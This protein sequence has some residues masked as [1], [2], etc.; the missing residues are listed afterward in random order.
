MELQEIKDL[1]IQYDQ[2]LEKQVQLNMH[3]LRKVELE[4]TRSALRKTATDPIFSLIFGAL[5]FIA[6]MPFTMNHI[7]LLPYAV[8]ALALGLYAVLLVIDSAYRLSII[9]KI[10]YEGPI[11]EI[12]SH[13]EKLRIHNLRYTLSLNLSWAILWF[14][15]PIIILKG[16]GGFD[17]YGLYHGWIV[18]NLVFCATFGVGLIAL[19]IWL[20]RRYTTDQIT[21]PWLKNLMNNL[22][23]HS[24]AKARASLQ[25]IEDFNR[26]N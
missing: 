11:T 21:Q 3:L 23:G 26:E 7:N 25:E 13:V 2:K 4:K 6:L 24:L 8:P 14:F 5:M 15:I 12:Q 22:A 19:V 17:F 1:W 16:L 10:D 9:K 18:W 20:A